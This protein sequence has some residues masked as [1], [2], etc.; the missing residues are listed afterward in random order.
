MVK[1]MVESAF[2]PA[3]IKAML[4]LK[5]EADK[6][7]PSEEALEVLA[8][9]QTDLEFCYSALG[10]VSRSFAVVIQQLPEE[11]KDAVCIFYLVLRA[12]DT[13]EDDMQ[14]D[15][16]E[17]LPMLRSFHE[18]CYDTEFT[19][20]GVGDQHDYVILL[21]NYDKIT[22]VFS[23]LEKGYQDVI[24][25]ITKRMGEGMADFAEKEM[26]SLEDFDLYCHYVAGL[27]GI[28]LSKLFANSGHESEAFFNMDEVSNSMGLFLQ[29]T[30]IIRDY[31]EDLFADR[32]FWPKDVWGKYADDLTFFSK[33]A[34]D[35]NINQC[36]NELV[37][38]ALR[39]V[40]DCIEYMSKL[41]NEK[42]FGFCAIP[43]VMAIATLAKV[44]NNKNVYTSC[45]KIRK[46]EAAVLMTSIRN[47]D[48]VKSVFYRYL[49]DIFA[50]IPK[51]DASAMLAQERIEG[52]LKELK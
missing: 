4:K 46:G 1:E 15:L 38:D 23:G 49:K 48:D 25:D 17:K 9:K 40:P 26:I 30:N 22:R 20:Q 52:L 11:L 18:K 14:F 33:H 51:N 2:K 10:K 16:E 29:K 28:G 21:E 13:V 6:Y 47:I 41:K 34:D 42:V 39:H 27:V 3:E 36:L 24:V 50:K 19:M 45:V 37:T 32:T 8:T 7:A 5:K 12:L 35:E 44:Y 31:H 43:Q